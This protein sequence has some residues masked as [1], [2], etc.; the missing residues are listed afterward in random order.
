MWNSI[1]ERIFPFIIALSAL[2]VS[3]SAAFYS[4]TGLSLLFAGA[5]FA[6]IIMASSLEIAKLVTASLLYQYWEKLNKVLRTYLTIAA[7][8]LILIT[9]A[10]IYGFLSAAYQA[11]ANKAGIVENQIKLLE[12]KKTSFEKIKGQYE[13]EKQSITQNITS[14]RN[15]LG[16]N[17]QSYVD[18]NGNVISY[19]SSAN[20]KSFEKQLEVAIQKDE[21]LTTKVQTYNDSIINLETRIVKTQNNSE[22]AAELG[23]LKYL[24]NLTGVTMDRI[25]N[26]FLLVIIF[27][28]D[29]LA[30][31]LVVAANFAFAQLKKK[32][33]PK[34][35]ENDEELE[36]ASLVDLQILEQEEQEKPIPVFMDPKSGKLYYEEP[37]EEGDEDHAQDMV[38]N[39]MV[40]DMTDEEI[41]EVIDTDGDGKISEEEL[42]NYI[43]NIDSDNSG[44]IDLEEAKKAGI[45]PELIDQINRLKSL[46]GSTLLSDPGTL[47]LRTEIA[48][49]KQQILSQLNKK[50]DD[51]DTITV[52]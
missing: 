12:T 23:P 4:V 20:R 51:D 25:I 3:A 29:P 34:P 19:S 35:L 31:A 47:G 13:V 6:V 18:N 43:N 16:N 17:N 38:L 27:V 44:D 10:G 26:W 30:I 15:A 2:S 5:S 11:T 9:S 28:F 7:F 48:F 42:I 32:D 22:V 46:L 40:E 37:E 21:Q 1:R 24:A 33:T 36:E 50:K 52:F 41:Q 14:L 8:I 45:D 39:A 49:L